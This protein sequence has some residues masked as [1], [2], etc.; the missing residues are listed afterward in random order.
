MKNIFVV[1]IIL[2]SSNVILGFTHNFNHTDLAG[3]D[4]LEIKTMNYTNSLPDSSVFINIY[5]PQ[6]NGMENKVVENQINS[7]LSDEFQQSIMWYE[8]LIAD[9]VEM[10]ANNNGF[11]YS[12]E[13]G[14]EVKYNSETF[15]SISLDHYQFTGGAHGNYYSLGYNI[16]LKDGKVLSLEDIINEDS[17]DMLSY[18]CGQ[19]IIDTFQVT[20]LL[21][22]GLFEDEINILPDQ[23]FYIIPG[24]LVLQFDPFEIAPYAMGELE[25][26]IPF[27]R[28]K[29]ILK[30]NLPFPAN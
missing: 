14:F 10:T 7:F 4:T 21:D 16:R 23:D 18:E 19:A 6:I 24:A 9:T 30:D 22:A 5:Y 3:T 27:D 13:T 8:E 17:F 26:R 28:I 15:L 25:V 12:F 20:S 29:D 11:S 2:I 1:F